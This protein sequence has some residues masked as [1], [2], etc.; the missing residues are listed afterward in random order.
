MIMI[1]RDL[2]VKCWLV[3]ITAAVQARRDEADVTRK[4]KCVN[5]RDPGE[6]RTVVRE[7]RRDGGKWWTR[8]TRGKVWCHVPHSGAELV[9]LQSLITI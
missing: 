4:R 5:V 8:V 9:T 3:L 1:S 7:W 2:P 6:V